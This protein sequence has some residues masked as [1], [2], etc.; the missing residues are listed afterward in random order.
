M[1]PKILLVA[2]TY[3]PKVDV[4]LKFIEEYVQRTHDFEISLLVPDYGYNKKIK[5]VQHLHQVQVSRFMQISGYQ[6]MSLRWKNLKIIKKAI[7][8]A[9]IV[10]V[11]GPALLSYLTMMIA[12]RMKKK[13]I[14]YLHV[15]T[16]ELFEKFLPSIIKK[17]FFKIFK[18][19]SISLYNRCTK[20]FL[21]YKALERELH[22]NGVSTQMVIAKLGVDIQR[23]SPTNEHQTAKKKINIEGKKVV[24]YVGRIS[25]E[26]NVNVLK[27]AFTKLENQQ[28][29][30]LLIVGDGSK[31][32]VEE[33]RKLPNCT[34]TGFVNDVQ[35]YLQAS[36]IF[37]MPSLTE[38]T[39]LAT[40]EAMSCGLP[41]IASKVGF[42]KDYIAKGHNGIFFPK[43]SSHHLALQLE[44]LLQNPELRKKLGANARRTI[45]YSFSWDRSINRINRLLKEVL[46]TTETN[47]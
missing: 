36:D 32:Q 30:H 42:I 5:N 8:E 15:I 2:D 44:K 38:T 12:P 17:L 31:E 3:M 4:T 41:V 47:D 29:L 27:E 24:T 37:V 40:L 39:S 6:S 21:P 28:D 25:K 14:F 34:V 19:W 23:F 45:A 18:W 33:F 13:T 11:Q 16:W 26:K 35:K 9:D 1:K 43:N 7:K 46:F 20:I 10:F 22:K